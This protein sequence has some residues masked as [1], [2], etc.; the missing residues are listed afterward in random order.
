MSAQKRKVTSRAEMKRFWSVAVHLRGDGSAHIRTQVLGRLSGRWDAL[1]R[2]RING[3]G[4]IA[5]NVHVWMTKHAQ[6]IVYQ[7]RSVRRMLYGQTAHYIRRGDTS[8]P[9]E[10]ARRNLSCG[11]EH[12]AIGGPFNCHT[13]AYLDT[14]AF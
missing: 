14:F 12:A 4:A 8:R 3:P 9:K 7:N 1:A 6:A 2:F 5:N 13:G 10:R 11:R